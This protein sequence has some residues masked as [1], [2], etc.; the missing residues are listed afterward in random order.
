MSIYK[1]LSEARK[2]FHKKAINKT[3]YNSFGKW[4]YFQ[5]EDIIPPALESFYDAGLV[6]YVSFEAEYATMAIVDVDDSSQIIRINSPTVTI[7]LKGA[8]E[9]QNL[10]AMQTYIRRYLW[11]TALDIV[12]SDAVDSSGQVSGI[13]SLDVD[14]LNACATKESLLELCKILSSKYA[15]GDILP[16]YNAALKNLEIK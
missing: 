8:T 13:T 15:K 2:A 10:G 4:Y 14:Q 6:S 7:S 9:I 16:F 12:E 5:L 3:G 11:L 1:K